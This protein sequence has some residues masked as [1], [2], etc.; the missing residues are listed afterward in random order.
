[1]TTKP[2]IHMDYS[3]EPRR[4]ILCIDVKSF[5]A[6]VEA[7]ERQ[8][9]PLESKICVVSK[10]NQQGGLVLAAA[11]RVKAEYGVKTGTRIY[12]IPKKADIMIVEPRM[13]LYLEKNLSILRIFKRYVTDLDL[14][15]YSIDESF[16]DVSASHQLFGTSYQIARA[17]QD[18]VWREL[19]LVV[20][21]GIGDNPLLAKLA[22][23]HETKKKAIT[24]YIANWRYQDVPRTVWHIEELDDFWG[25]GSR[26]KAK[27][28]RLGIDSIYD[29]AQ[30][31]V[32]LLKKQFGVIGEQLF[33]HAHGIDRTRLSDQYIPE[34]SS[35]SRN[36]ILNRDYTSAYEIK[37]VISEMTEENAMRLR[38][39]KQTTGLVKLK[40]G[41]SRDILS[42][43]FS[44]Q[45][46]IDPTD[47]SKKLIQYL[48]QIFN[49]YY[50]DKPVRI[51]NVTFGHIEQKQDLQLNFFE[52]P[53]EV[54]IDERKESVID[55]I[56][57]RF[58]NTAILPANSLIDG[59]MAIYRD[60]LL[61]GHQADTKES[62]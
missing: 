54:L 24:H 50:E 47:S 16:L 19:G 52:S 7:V 1:M 8:I 5:F 12:E 38:K 42:P 23:D 45:L 21:I 31:D 11:P 29:L 9:H 22:L 17:I 60:T 61:G 51:V 36:Q 27:L 49:E 26:T 18:D 14:H 37:I 62:T 48:L 57:K 33:F 28:Q 13:S 53:E 40:I 20:T 35:Y 25:I 3:N 59:S 46:K 10:P 34:S 56:K 39:H 15:P 44:H 6:S 43:G 32:Q 41:Y 30:S 2:E 4:D 58:G 55:H